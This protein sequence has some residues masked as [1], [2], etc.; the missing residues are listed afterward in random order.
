MNIA[1]F[2]KTG[3][4]LDSWLGFDVRSINDTVTI[5]YDVLPRTE[6]L[7]QSLMNGDVKIQFDY[8]RTGWS[9]T[10]YVYRLLK[11]ERERWEPEFMELR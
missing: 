10:G 4:D 8:D 7:H 3:Y 6:K 11:K 2:I 1:G 9:E 5:A